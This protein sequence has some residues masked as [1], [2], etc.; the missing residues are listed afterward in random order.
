MFLENG[1]VAEIA[2]FARAHVLVVGDVMLD[3]FATGEVER[4]SPE[5]PIPVFRTVRRDAT[6]GGAGN[7]V[8]N[9][10][11]LG[12]ECRLVSVVGGDADAEAI[13]DMLREA[14]APV[15][16]LV[17]QV[18]RQTTVKERFFAHGQQLLRV[19]QET[20]AA[21][22]DAS[23][24][25][26]LEHVTAHCRAYPVVV[27]S[28]YGKGVL[29]PEVIAAAIGAATA[30][31]ARV[32]VDPKGTDYARY[33][34]A[35]LLTPNARELHQATGLATGTDDEVVAAC[36]ALIAGCGVGGVLA[37]RSERGMTLVTAEAPAVHL[38]AE[39]R[40][41]YDVT[42]AGDTVVAALAA[43]V[44]A[45]L[46][47][48]RA[49]TI[50]N[51]AA[52][53]V[54]G[55]RGTARAEPAEILRAMNGHASTQPLGKLADAPALAARLEL[56]RAM[57]LR[58]GF[59]NGCFDL[60][61]PGH[62]SLLKQARAACDY[63]IVGLNSDASVRR[64]KGPD[65]PAQDQAARAAILASL[66]LVDQVVI[67]DGDTPASLIE[68]IRPDVLVKGADYR[69]ENVV[70]GDFVESYGGRVVLAEISQGFST[71]SII[72]RFPAR[73]EASAETG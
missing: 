70:G 19:D 12:A 16:G 42:G 58:I 3:R 11:G 32:L 21:I 57:H 9:L 46:P 22:S 17:T 14:G 63:L 41:V 55:K 59:T 13:R 62:L 61:H 71:T 7:V 47:A 38:K 56:C 4:I 44:A 6:L 15:D 24:E 25:R 30:A 37:T 54:V 36:R 35:W 33:R 23:R 2:G 49:A 66:S 26:L 65:R 20:T 73:S 72:G 31:G 51:V 34:G 68:A 45:G 8:N 10:L 52:G 43:G 5:A 1:H 60:L 48:A 50:A 67:F 69:R 39:S 64:L 29:T 27:L 40:E 53:I 18:D 28:D